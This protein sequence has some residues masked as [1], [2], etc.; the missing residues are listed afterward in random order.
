MA[1]WDPKK[2]VLYHEFDKFNKERALRNVDQPNLLRNIFPKRK[3]PGP[4]SIL[5]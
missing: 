5:P 3:S 4:T 1:K 2:G